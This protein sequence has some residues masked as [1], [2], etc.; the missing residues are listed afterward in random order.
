MP[1]GHI[2]GEAVR[3]QLVKLSSVAR[4]TLNLEYA[5]RLS[6]VFLS[7][8]FKMKISGYKMSP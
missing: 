6:S 3:G 8:F 2:L 7:I 4:K 1:N 5:F